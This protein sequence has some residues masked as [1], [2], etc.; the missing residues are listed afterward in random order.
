[1]ERMHRQFADLAKRTIGKRCSPLSGA[2]RPGP[3]FC[4]FAFLDASLEP[5]IDLVMKAVGLEACVRDAD[6]VITGEGCLDAQ[7]VMGKVP[8]GVKTCQKIRSCRDRRGRQRRRWEASLC[9]QAGIDAF[10]PDS[11]WSDAAG[12]CH[13]SR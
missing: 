11:A 12:G 10:F 8:A 9:N 1:M 4:I 6:F 5:G 13:A 7:T 3:R 2:E